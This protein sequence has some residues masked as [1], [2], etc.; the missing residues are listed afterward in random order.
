M[1]G[2]GELIPQQSD[3]LRQNHH[4]VILVHGMVFQISRN[5]TIPV[6]DLYLFDHSMTS[7]HAT[8]EFR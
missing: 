8:A 2:Y 4:S 1:V 3:C 7:A 5:N 6:V